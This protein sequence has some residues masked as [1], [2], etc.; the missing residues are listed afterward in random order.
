VQPAMFVHFDPE[1]QTYCRVTVPAPSRET[2]GMTDQQVAKL[3]KIMVLVLALG[4]L[5]LAVHSSPTL[6]VSSCSGTPG[7][8]S[9]SLELYSASSQGG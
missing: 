1:H 3:A 2:P 8:P 7:S 9:Y 5:F 6:V 4:A